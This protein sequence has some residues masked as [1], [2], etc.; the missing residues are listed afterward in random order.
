[1]ITDALISMITGL[2]NTVAGLL[3]SHTLALPDLSGV[4]QWIA[5]VDS[6][7]PIGGVIQVG[8]Y[9]LA[10]GAVF[11]TVRLLMMAWKALPFT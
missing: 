1:M 2:F 5:D 3:P 11:V 7:L 6:V 4:K 9:V 10:L 8:V